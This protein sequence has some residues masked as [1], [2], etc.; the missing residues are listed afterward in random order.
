MTSKTRASDERTIELILAPSNLGLR[1]LW[2]G[3]VPGTWR[4][5][6]ALQAA[7]LE[8]KVLP[9]RVRHL[10]KP[11]YSPELQPGT[12]L[13]NGHE[14][15]RFNLELAAQVFE[16]ASDRHFCL[17]IGGDCSILLGALAAI[18]RIEPVALF[19]IDGHSDFRHP[20][21]YDPERQIGA[22]AGMDLALA[23]GR[24]EPLLTE[25]PGAAA[26]LVPDALVFQL[27]ERE[28][29]DP[30][31]AWP[32]I[33]ATQINRLEIFD[34]PVLGLK[35]VGE[36]LLRFTEEVRLGFWIHLDIDVLDGKIMPAVDSP[37][38]P[39][40]SVEQ[41]IEL[42]KPLAQHQR[43]LGASV[44]VFDP[45]L[46]PDGVFATTIADLTAEIFAQ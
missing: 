14:I 37:G 12:R 1:P 19:H 26:P 27:G 25:W 22:V 34:V 18:R 45:D 33:A 2:K 44:S 5:P 41:L 24:G 40:L 42:T 20:G 6:E 29:R 11:T 46:D 3:H 32:D 31:F 30:D 4:A 9:A 16:V 36:R 23:T 15:R 10:S 8:G 43:C 7:G 13:Y 39:G 38:S 17:V 28:S 21:N 35:G